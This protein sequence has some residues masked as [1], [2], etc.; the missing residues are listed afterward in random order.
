MGKVDTLFA[1]DLAQMVAFTT[2]VMPEN[3][4]IG[5]HMSIATYIH[6]ARTEILQDALEQGATHILWLDSDMRF[7]KDTAIRLLQRQVP[8]VGINYSTRVMPPGFVGIKRVPR[9]DDPTDGERLQTTDAT[10]GLEECDALGFGAFM[11]EAA[12]LSRLPDP[13][14]T[15]WFWFE[16]TEFG[17]TIGE[18]VYFCLKMI[19]DHLGERIFCDQDLSKECGH[20]GQFEYKFYHPETTQEVRE[21][22]LASLEGD[23]GVGN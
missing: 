9:G 14:Y 18:D 11:M 22:Y 17:Q 12:P 3:C 19:Q 1:Y 5:I 4:S 20:L 7:P 23:D 10:T 21:E 2:A 6:K 8:F 13:D 16:K 15:P